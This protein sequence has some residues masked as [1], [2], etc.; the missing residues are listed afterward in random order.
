[1]KKPF[2]LISEAV[3]W[4]YELV[5]EIGMNITEHGGPHVDYVDKENNCGIA[6]VVMIETSHISLHVWDKQ[7]PPLVQMDVYSCSDYNEDAVI[8]FLSEME[9]SNIDYLV[10]DRKE[11]LELQDETIHHLL[12]PESAPHH[13]P[14]A[15]QIDPLGLP[16]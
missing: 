7:D 5:D 16:R 8:A 3:T 15:P 6:G 9:P 1:V 12:D 10:I 11:S 4:L 2:R 14:L 13:H